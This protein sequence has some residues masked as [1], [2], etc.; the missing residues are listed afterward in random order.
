MDNT[1]SGATFFI[2]K[3]SLL[4]FSKSVGSMGMKTSME[5]FK[6]SRNDYNK[7]IHSIYTVPASISH[8]FY[9]LIPLILIK[10]L[11]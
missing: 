8:N 1:T 5:A 6:L 11:R 10:L 9:I 4:L 3:V 2:P 7:H